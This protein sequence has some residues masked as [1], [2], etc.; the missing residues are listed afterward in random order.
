MFAVQKVSKVFVVLFLS[1]YAT[2]AM[3]QDKDRS[4]SPR[5]DVKGA[6]Q[7]ATSEATETLPSSSPW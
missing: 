2:G 7:R 3:A 6:A 1:A 5:V 4:D